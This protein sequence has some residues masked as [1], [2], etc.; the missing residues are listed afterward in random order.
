MTRLPVKVRLSRL[1]RLSSG[2]DKSC[3]GWR[4]LGCAVFHQT[5]AVAEAPLKLKKG[6]SGSAGFSYWAKAGGKNCVDVKNLAEYWKQILMTVSPLA[7]LEKVAAIVTE[8]PSPLAL[9]AAYQSCHSLKERQE[10]LTNIL[11]AD[12]S[13]RIHTIMTCEDPDTIL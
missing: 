10:L 13:R 12:I 2:F 5:R 9:L 4:D 11:G 6:I 1:S 3:S 8:Y 7:G